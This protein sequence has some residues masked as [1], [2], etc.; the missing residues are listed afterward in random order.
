VNSRL[1]GRLIIQPQLPRMS[2]TRRILG[3]FCNT[4]TQNILSSE[5]GRTE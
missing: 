3:K 4:V 1:F 5:C 2:L